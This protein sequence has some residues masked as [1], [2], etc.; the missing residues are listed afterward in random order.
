[1][2]WLCMSSHSSMD[3]ALAQCLGGH[4]FKSYKDSDFFL[5][6]MLVLHYFHKYRNSLDFLITEKFVKY[7]RTLLKLT[8]FDRIFQGL[9]SQSFKVNV[10]HISSFVLG[11]SWDP[12]VNFLHCETPKLP[13]QLIIPT[14][15]TIIIIIITLICIAQIQY[16]VQMRFTLKLHS[17]KI[18]YNN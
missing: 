8:T 17:P 15:V 13:C 11:Y 2:T 3:R 10:V 5:G 1:M 7:V 16:N 6:P 14:C 9:L 4:G 12:S 18:R